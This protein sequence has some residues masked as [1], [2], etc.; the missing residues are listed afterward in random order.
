MIKVI[1]K[2]NSI[3]LKGILKKNIKKNKL[4]KKIAINSPLKRIRKLAVIDK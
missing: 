1:E 4:N 2:I 3:F